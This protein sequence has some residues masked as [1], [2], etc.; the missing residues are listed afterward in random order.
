MLIL[1]CHS[2]L[3]LSLGTLIKH[4][5]VDHW[6]LVLTIALFLQLLR[7]EENFVN[8]AESVVDYFTL[9]HLVLVL[10]LIFLLVSLLLLHLLLT[11]MR[12]LLVLLLLLLEDTMLSFVAFHSSFTFLLFLL[13][14]II[15]VMLFRYLPILIS[16]LLLLWILLLLLDLLLLLLHLLLICSHIGGLLY[17]LH[18]LKGLFLRLYCPPLIHGSLQVL[19]GA[20][21]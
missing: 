21:Q 12:I 10:R 11:L 18:K 20:N 4:Q 14:L 7:H 16:V 19:V 8:L 1:L 13:L 5:V 9:S 15:V 6:L 2:N 3:L 17:D